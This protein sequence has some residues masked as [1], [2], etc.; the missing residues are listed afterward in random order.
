MLDFLRDP[1]WQFFGFLVGLLALVVGTWASLRGRAKK[2]AYEV[3]SQTPLLNFDLGSTDRRLKLLFNGKPIHNA[4]II[5]IELIN[6]G[7]APIK[8][9]DYERPL[10]VIT[11]ESSKIL[12]AQVVRKYPSGL[13]VPISNVEGTS[14]TVDPIL[15]NSGD[16]FVIQA[17][18]VPEVEISVDGRIAGVKEIKSEV[19]KRKSRRV[20]TTV[21]IWVVAMAISVFIA[22][23]FAD[24]R[25]LFVVVAAGFS[26]F[27][28]GVVLP[29]LIDWI[30]DNTS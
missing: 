3:I 27:F 14:I 26:T 25:T 4:E 30:R 2:L 21:F 23:G 7:S 1:I 24:Y 16:Y 20:M 5:L 18:V 13:V 22:S 8:P 15:L 29:R 12:D 6:V 17:I 9:G 19:H 11:G 10:K 28:G